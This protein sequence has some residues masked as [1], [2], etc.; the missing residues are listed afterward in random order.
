MKQTDNKRKQTCAGILFAC[1]F[2][3]LFSCVKQ[4]I[5]Y[6]EEQIRKE[7]RIAVVLPFSKGMEKRWHNSVDWAL[8]NLNTPLATRQQIKIT[9]E[10]YDED[11]YDMDELFTGLAQREDIHA[12]VGPLY[13]TN[14]RTAARH[15]AAT[16]KT[17]LPALA[18]SELMMRTYTEKG[19]LWCL[20]ENDISQCEV[21]LTRALQ[22]G[23][24]SVSLLTCDNIYGQTFFDWFAFQAKELNLDVHSTAV[25]NENNIREKMLPLLGEETD[26]LICI[27]SGNPATEEMN[28]VRISYP[29][30]HPFLFFSDGAFLMEPDNTYEGM[31]GIVQ[32]HDPQ[33]GFSIAYE[34]KFGEAPE[35]GNA[36][37]YDAVLL[38]GLGILKADLSRNTD[39]NSAIR[40]LVDGDG[41]E[42][43]NCSDEGV[44]RLIAT[45]VAGEKPHMTGA[46]G[47]L[48][49][50]P[51][52]YTNVIHSIYCHWIVYLG[53]HLILEYNT[54]DS[55]N[56]TAASVA[57]W[58]WRVT[59]MQ[60]FS[61]NSTY[62]YPQKKGLYAIIVAGSSGWENYRHQADTYAFYQLLKANGLDDRH[63]LLVAEDDIAR[64]P[65][66]P[67]FGTVRITNDGKNLYNGISIDYH[68]SELSWEE[69]ERILTGTSSGMPVGIFA[70]DKE[71]NLLIYWAGHGVKEGPLWLD[72]TIPNE[73]VA[74][75]FRKMAEEERFRKALFIIET[76][77]SGRIGEACRNIP[78]LLCITAANTDETSKVKNYSYS[79]GTWLSNSFTDA[80]LEE[81]AFRPDKDLYTIY[82]TI[83]NRTMGSHVSIYNAEHFDNLYTASTG[84]FL[85]F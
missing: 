32:T 27:S 65:A 5:I 67:E 14:A 22:K 83:Y 2:L 63:I 50:D 62:A 13:S 38:A 73:Q 6:P 53:Q 78:H 45:L 21:L 24:K 81:F 30:T 33:S 15:C 37:F 71:D 1:I 3:F 82:S 42:I 28:E 29:D 58:N 72:R 19:F 51:S 44:A 8:E 47:K 23:A 57:N 40:Q 61:D 41:E 80:I 7:Y 69:F 68:P 48:R 4:R 20:T 18:S 34:I 46:S 31:E 35:Y 84:E 26:C 12:I 9:A 79:L 43:N 55:N 60:Q 70:P 75:L 49:F 77:Y 66:N 39:I 59:R 11:K 76:C 17:L 36:H 16:S 85:F 54:S 52:L 74:G 25:Y 64:N 56:R 10:W